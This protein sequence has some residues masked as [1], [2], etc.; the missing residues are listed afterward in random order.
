MILQVLADAVEPM[1][2]RN[3]ARLQSF[4]PADARQLEQLR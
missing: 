3:A 1:H 2:D 4:R